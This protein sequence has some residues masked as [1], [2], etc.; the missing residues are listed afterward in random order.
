MS[1]GEEKESS[2]ED[3]PMGCWLKLAGSLK[4]FPF[5]TMK[6][7]ELLDKCSEWSKKAGEEIFKEFE[8]DKNSEKSTDSNSK[9]SKRS[10]ESADSTGK[11][12]KSSKESTNSA[13]KEHK[14]SKQSKESTN[15]TD[16]EPKQSDEPANSNSKETEQSEEPKESADSNS[17]ESKG[18][19]VTKDEFYA[20]YMIFG[21]DVLI[22]F[23]IPEERIQAWEDENL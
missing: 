19:D 18:V 16:N 7:N 14:E 20:F 2:S 17:K 12:L 8:A 21:R 23:G 22:E 5:V 15:S 4:T 3:N 11:E 6:L 9:E 13:D 1:S 10:K